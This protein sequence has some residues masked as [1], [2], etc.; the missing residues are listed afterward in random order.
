MVVDWAAVALGGLVGTLGLTVIMAAATAAGLARLNFPMLLGTFFGPPGPATLAI[1]FVWHFVNGVL[2]A[3]VYG[4]AFNALGL[5]PTWLSGAGFGAVHTIIAGGLLGLISSIHPL[6]R[7]GRM[8][9]PRA[10]GSRYGSPG[11]AVLLLAHLV[12][13][14]IVGAVL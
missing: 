9:A 6:I 4:L 5:A 2:F 8:P 12:F 11:V 13:G 7:A 10:F 14:G 3:I 1:G